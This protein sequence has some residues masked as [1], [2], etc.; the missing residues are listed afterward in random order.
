LRAPRHAYE[1]TPAPGAVSAW[2]EKT[3]SRRVH[4]ASA[5]K[6]VYGRLAAQGWSNAMKRAAMIAVM[7]SLVAPGA[8]ALAQSGPL[9]FGALGCADREILNRAEL[10]KLGCQPLADL[11]NRIYQVAG[12]GGVLRADGL[13]AINVAQIREIERLKGCR[14]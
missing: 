9:C 4:L 2:R 5:I 13:E 14:P 12:A 11:R 6:A 7:L 1:Y 10:F 3:I 8:G